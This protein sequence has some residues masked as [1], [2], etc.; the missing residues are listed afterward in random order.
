[1]SAPL[2]DRVSGWDGICGSVLACDC[3]DQGRSHKNTATSCLDQMPRGLSEDLYSRQV[4]FREFTPVISSTVGH[5]GPGHDLAGANNLSRAGLPLEQRAS[6]RS[7]QAHN[8]G[9]SFTHSCFRLRAK[10]SLNVSGAGSPL[11][12]LRNGAV[13]TVCISGTS[14]EAMPRAR[15]SE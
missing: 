9:A 4:R 12:A 8:S 2:A 6:D 1:M 5:M 10:S 3:H 11:K 14:R 13:Y 15:S 7:Q